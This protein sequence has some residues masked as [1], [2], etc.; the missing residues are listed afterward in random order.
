MIPDVVLYLFI[1]KSIILIYRDDVATTQLAFCL[2]IWGTNPNQE[3]A[4]YFLP[5]TRNQ[6]DR[7]STLKPDYA[8]CI[9]SRRPPFLR[10][11]NLM[12]ISNL[13]LPQGTS[14]LMLRHHM[15]ITERGECAI[16]SGGERYYTQYQ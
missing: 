12:T 15:L 11:L 8:D 5:G 7:I 14:V 16:P 1:P 2:N 13:Q 10:T 9:V 4:T 6:A 3:G